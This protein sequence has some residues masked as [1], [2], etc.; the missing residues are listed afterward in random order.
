MGEVSDELL[1]AHADGELAPQAARQLEAEMRVD[2]ELRRRQL[3]FVA[4]RAPL[5]ELFDA[6][7]HEA[8]PAWLVQSIM[9][10][11][12]PSASA[13]APMAAT[14]SGRERVKAATLSDWFAR[15]RLALVR[16]LPSP[17]MAL[18]CSTA[19]LVGTGAGW[20]IPK[21][22]PLVT[23]A[24][25]GL[26]SFQSG[27]LLAHGELRQALESMPS[28]TT[29]AL[30]AAGLSST[31]QSGGSVR[32]VATFQNGQQNYCREYELTLAQGRTFE[33]V[34]CRSG[35]GR[36]QIEMQASATLTASPAGSVKWAGK[37]EGAVDPVIDRM[38]AGDV[39]A[40]D[41]ES[42]LIGKGWQ[43]DH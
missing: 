40:M 5:A 7:M 8:A 1:M 43:H 30:A 4:T 29:L 32:P 31:G 36:W 42:R 12:A 19:L 27:T 9:G 35:E 21:N 33:G 13:N 41:D 37:P 6:P 23:S 34:A 22:G 18:A 24:S 11:A 38:I 25:E 15:L 20:S 39:L 28:G 26:I 17:Q 14:P 10:Q 2:P 3:A 16:G